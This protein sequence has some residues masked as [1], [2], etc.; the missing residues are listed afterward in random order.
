MLQEPLKTPEERF[1]EEAVQL[2]EKLV[3][4]F[5]QLLARYKKPVEAQ[6]EQE[7][8]E[9]AARISVLLECFY[10]PVDHTDDLTDEEYESL[11][12]QL[13]FDVRDQEQLRR[14]W[15]GHIDAERET[16]R[17]LDVQLRGD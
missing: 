10:E 16:I 8:G 14:W 11:N 13:G 7:K 5:A 3:E 6:S 2:V 12:Q 9:I 15:Q 17:Q 4:D 1:N